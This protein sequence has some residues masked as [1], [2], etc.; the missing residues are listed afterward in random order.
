MRGRK[1]HIL[2]DSR[3]LLLGIH[4]TAANLH[5]RRGAGQLRERYAARFP[6]LGLI[7][8]DRNYGGLFPA[9]ALNFHNMEVVLT[10]PEALANGH[11]VTK[12]RWV[13]ERTFA[14]L[15]RNR[16]LSK[17]YEFLVRNSES[18]IYLAMSRLMWRRLARLGGT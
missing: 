8:A 9:Y 7:W 6:K 2:V 14:W 10:V 16:R 1:R 13:V 17:D 15:G 18:W 3:G 4:L 11:L 5:D 12:K